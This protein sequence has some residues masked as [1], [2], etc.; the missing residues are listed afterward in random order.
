MIC[1]CVHSELM[2]ILFLLEHLDL[3]KSMEG[4]RRHAHYDI[5]PHTLEVVRCLSKGCRHRHKIR[6]HLHKVLI[7]LSVTF[8]H[9]QFQGK[10]LSDDTTQLC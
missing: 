2:E 5:I 3:G 9:Q 4:W 1:K 6:Q 7:T 10:T 8:A